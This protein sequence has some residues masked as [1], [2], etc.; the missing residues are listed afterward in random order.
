[1]TNQPPDRLPS[2]HRFALV[3]VLAVYPVITAVLYALAPFTQDW[4]TWQRTML[5]APIMVLS[6][7]YAVAPG[8][9]WGLRKYDAAR[10]P[11]SRT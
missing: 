9:Q 4:A 6:I 5:I 8:V 7:V 3:M 2:R 11:D 10:R 1:M